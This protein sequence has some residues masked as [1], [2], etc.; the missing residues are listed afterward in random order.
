M[1][2][3]HREALIP[4]EWSERRLDQAAAALWPEFSR[5]RIK[6][7][8]TAGELLLDGQSAIPRARVVEGQT[9]RLD[10]RLTDV[11]PARPEAIPL[12]VVFEDGDLLVIDKPA[13]LVVHP[14]AGNASG[15]LQN[16]LLNLDPDLGQLPRAG[17]IHRLDKDTTGLLLVARTLGAHSALVAALEQREIQRHY[18]AICQ[19]PMVAGGLVDA[20][21]ARHPKD[22]VRMAVAA[23]GGRPA[24]THYRVAERFR[25]HT[26]L[27]VSLETGRTHQIRVHMAHIRHPLVGDRLYGGR[28]RL[29]TQ[30][31]PELVDALHN[32]PRQA[33]HACR[34]ELAHPLRGETITLESPLPPDLVA[35]LAVLRADGKNASEAAR[36]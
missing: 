30:P 5:S 29:P 17:I 15:T 22:R 27:N 31:L 28:S 6:Q 9:I 12:T 21:I 1:T 13:G 10:T 25:A 20:A 23:V 16:A 11:G 4:A 36:R 34:L 35:L 7:W 33:L 18:Q 26:F 2:E 24:R 19:G 14:G 3:I 8:I 32:F